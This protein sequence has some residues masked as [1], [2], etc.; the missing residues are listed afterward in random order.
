MT[1]NG[2]IGKVH[3]HALAVTQRGNAHQRADGLD[4]APRLADEAADV[5]VRQLD[6]DRHSPAAAL[7]GLDQDLLGLLGQR[8]RDEF[9]ERP[10]IDSRP[11]RGRP[12]T[13][14]TT[15][16]TTAVETTAAEVTPRRPASLYVAQGFPPAS[17]GFARLR[18][19]ERPAAATSAL[20]PRRSSPGP[21]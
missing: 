14:K 5:L 2:R 21:A 15:T 9:H 8:L 17:T 4:V 7:E 12:V 11:V 18:S 20:C 6:L 19:A 16:A 3:E 1:W 13:S 10:V